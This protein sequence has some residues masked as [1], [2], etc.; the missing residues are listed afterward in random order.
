MKSQANESLRAMIWT[1]AITMTL[2][3]ATA[4]AAITGWVPNALGHTGDSPSPVKVEWSR[5]DMTQPVTA[6]APRAVIVGPRAPRRP[7]LVMA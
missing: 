6:V 1:A 7:S 4:I 3:C 2:F 5:M